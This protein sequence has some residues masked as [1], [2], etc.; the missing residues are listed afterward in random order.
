MEKAIEKKIKLVDFGRTERQ[1]KRKRERV[2]VQNKLQGTKKKQPTRTN[3]KVVG[4]RRQKQNTDRIGKIECRM[5][6][7][8]SKDRNEQ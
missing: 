8:D 6:L 7:Q 1:D 2:A 4:G 3:R 5:Q